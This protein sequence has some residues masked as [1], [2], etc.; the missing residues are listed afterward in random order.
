MSPPACRDPLVMLGGC[1]T[2][3]SNIVADPPRVTHRLEI[4]V[5]SE[6]HAQRTATC[7]DPCWN[8]REVAG[9]ATNI[10]LEGVPIK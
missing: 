8:P 4:G 5:A 7:P 6:A 2:S 3:S 9:G 1:V 10:H